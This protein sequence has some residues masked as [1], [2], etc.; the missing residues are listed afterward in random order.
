ML[1]PQMHVQVCQLVQHMPVQLLQ[2]HLVADS[3][4]SASSAAEAYAIL[5]TH[6]DQTTMPASLLFGGKKLA[7]VAD[8]DKS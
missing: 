5:M 1:T 4:E 7:G 2:V 3:A 6:Q 8:P